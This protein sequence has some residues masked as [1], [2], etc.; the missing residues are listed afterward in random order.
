MKRRRFSEEKIIGTLKEHQARLGAKELCRER[1]ISD[2]TCP[3]H[4]F[5]WIRPT[6]SLVYAIFVQ[7]H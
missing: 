7:H 6:P 4:N 3:Y 2:A 5:V 1:G